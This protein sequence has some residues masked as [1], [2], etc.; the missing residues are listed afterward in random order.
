MNFAPFPTV[1]VLLLLCLFT[2]R[3][4]TAQSSFDTSFLGRCRVTATI[5]NESLRPAAV[6]WGVVFQGENS[7]VAR[8]WTSS[9]LPPQS[10]NEYVLEAEIPALAWSGEVGLDPEYPVPPG[11][12]IVSNK[13]ESTPLKSVW[14][15]PMNTANGPVDGWSAKWIV[16]NESKGLEH[17]NGIADKSFRYFSREFTVEEKPG[18]ALLLVSADDSA[19]VWMNGR[20][21]GETAQWQV[22]KCLDVT[23]QIQVGKP[24]LLCIELYNENAYY[25]LLAELRLVHGSD[26]GEARVITDAAWLADIRKPDGWPGRGATQP[27]IAFASAGGAPWGTLPD[28]M[29]AQAGTSRAPMLAPLAQPNFPE[30]RVVTEKNGRP[31]IQV[32]GQTAGLVQYLDFQ[33]SDS[34]VAANLKTSNVQIVQVGLDNFGW[35][36]EGA[37]DFSEVD[38]RL[39]RVLKQ[40]P[41]AW[42]I[43]V[44]EIGTV[45]GWWLRK[46]PEAAALAPPGE[47]ELTAY[48]GAKG[49]FPCYVHPLWRQAVEE[50]YCQLLRHLGSADYGQRII[51]VKHSNG[52]SNEWFYWGSQSRQFPD[53]NPAMLK[54]Y[55]EWLRKE[56]AAVRE[57]EEARLPDPQAWRR[58]KGFF[59]DPAESSETIRYARFWQEMVADTVDWWAGIAKRESQGRLLVGNYYGYTL[60]LA[61]DPHFGQLAG[62]MAMSKLLRSPNVD[63]FYAPSDGYVYRKIG[64]PG[65]LMV[66]SGSIALHGKL[67][68]SEA[69]FRTHWSMQDVAR[70]KSIAEDVAI[71][72]REFALSFVTGAAP[73][74]LDFSQGYQTMDERLMR[75]IGRFQ[76]IYDKVKDQEV[77]FDSSELAVITGEEAEVQSLENPPV[78]GALVSAQRP[79][80]FRAGIRHQY[81]LSSDIANPALRRFRCFLFLNCWKLDDKQREAV[82]ALKSGGRT[83]IFVY[84]PGA[85]DGKC[86]SADLLSHL[87][88]LPITRLPDGGELRAKWLADG[89]EFGLSAGKPVPVAFLPGQGDEVLAT[90]PGNAEPMLVR[91]KFKR[92]TAVY[93]AVP[94]LT[95]KVL[96]ELAREAGL[97]IYCET[98]DASY[99]SS[100]LFGLHAKTDGTK[101]ITLPGQK[102]RIYNAVTGETLATDT[103]RFSFPAT[104][105]Q[106]YL[107]GWD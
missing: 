11:I 21:I 48:K 76:P 25:G 102:R 27:A 9:T 42:L 107:F 75:E 58:D 80:L 24:N 19:K 5:G 59:R 15:I 20:L 43:P 44:I 92:W 34:R 13:V 90:R 22:P 10:R 38:R 4:A 77:F 6:K 104:A 106:T 67:Y 26:K 30:A 62:H 51:G 57:I 96:R 89:H 60:H 103:R 55:Q 18:Q 41:K 84:A 32:N 56:G 63:I 91:H 17:Y 81:F 29:P 97:P 23:S 95:P 54:A 40:H 100:A 33:G 73:Q 39:R 87:T 14:D 93:S 61:E 105:G 74:L 94:H 16:A 70:T 99:P 53:Y 35:Q 3:A 45:T 98:D 83:L 79:E 68:A 36:G 2:S 46:H 28:P 88:G 78:F 66:P 31:R 85:W 12:Q 1:P 86:L 72:R 50:A 47:P 52:I 7:E 65:G 64:E 82:E 8:V 69:D 101:S 71:F 49:P 37:Y